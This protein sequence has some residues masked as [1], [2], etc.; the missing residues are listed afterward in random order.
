MQVYDKVRSLSQHLC[1]LG[2]GRRLSRGVIRL[3]YLFRVYSAFLQALYTRN[4]CRAKS[5][6]HQ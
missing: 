6:H 5:I 4:V 1:V 3:L 2:G